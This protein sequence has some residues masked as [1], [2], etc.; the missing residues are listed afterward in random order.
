M[1][2]WVIGHEVEAKAENERTE[3]RMRLLVSCRGSELAVVAAA[4]GTTAM[5]VDASGKGHGYIGT[6]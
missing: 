3:A 2:V 6:H 5:D 1:A 4:A